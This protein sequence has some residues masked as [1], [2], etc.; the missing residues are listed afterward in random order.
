MTATVEDGCS[1]FDACTE[2]VVTP[3][4]VPD[5]TNG[6]ADEHLLKKLE[7]DT[8]EDVLEQI[9]R[10]LLTEAETDKVG[11]RD[12]RGE[13][14]EVTVTPI[15]EGDKFALI[16][17]I[18]I[19]A[20]APID[21]VGRTVDDIVIVSARLTVMTVVTVKSI[22]VTD[23]CELR[24]GIEDEIDDGDDCRLAE[25]AIDGLLLKDDVSDLVPPLADEECVVE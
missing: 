16:L 2:M 20:L 3:L 11:A 6:V 24:V 12:E 15:N 10:R 4:V 1:E 23:T 25:S 7:A 14:E 18:L 22:G 9:L 5:G 19:D 8:V 17:A 21:I 13:L